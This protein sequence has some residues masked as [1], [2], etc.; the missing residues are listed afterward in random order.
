[1]PEIKIERSY[2]SRRINCPSPILVAHQPEFMP[3]LGNISKAAMGDVYFI[4][5][6]V[7]YQSKYFQNRN[8]IR[9]KNGQG[10]Q[11]LIIPVN[12]TKDHYVNTLDVRIANNMDWRKKHLHAI[13]F[14]YKKSAFFSEI[15]SE[16]TELYKFECDFLV[17]FLVRII[18]Y[19]FGKF[20][21]RIPVYRVS[22]LMKSGYVVKGEKSELII[23][24]CK[25]VDAKTYVF[26]ISGR[27][28]VEKDKFESVGIDVVF[29]DFNHP[30][31]QQVHG[32]FLPTMSFIDLLFNHGDRASE[33]LGKSRW[34]TM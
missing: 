19:A 17:D 5:D 3:W 31:Y 8:K 22:E 6:T 16:L 14:S 18:N 7:Q 21:I 12:D 25:V 26:G 33:I 10:W 23:S 30:V 13:E 28:Y 1:M 11:W 24:M 34:T 9:I 4:L 20:A 32:E 2:D 29:Q 15:F 27:D